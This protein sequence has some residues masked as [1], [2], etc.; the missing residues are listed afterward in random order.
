MADVR[1]E[2][3][4]EFDSVKG[5]YGVLGQ[6]MSDLLYELLRSDSIP[7]STVNFRVKDRDSLA[8]KITRKPQGH[9]QN[10]TDVTDIC[11]VRI[12]TYFED[13]VARVDDLIRREFLVDEANF[14]NK[15]EDLEDNEFGYRSVHEIISLGEP[16]CDLPENKRIKGLKAEVQ[17]RSI[18]QHAWA[19]IEHDLG[20]KSKAAVPRLVRRRFFRLAGLLELADQ[21]FMT[22]RGELE[23]YVDELPQEIVT[24]PSEVTIDK[25]SLDVFIKQD[26]GLRNADEEICELGKWDLDDSANL[27]MVTRLAAM[28]RLVDVVT[29]EQLSDGLKANHDLM[30]E[31]AGHWINGGASSSSANYESNSAPRGVAILYL[32]YVMM[33]SAGNVDIVEKFVKDHFDGNSTM[34]SR[35]ENTYRRVKGGSE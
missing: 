8:K 11:G 17:I 20:Y 5:H 18:L 34:V 31:F 26:A 13:D 1:E 24:K 15:F 27:Y 9:Y 21:E 3:L 6:K 33:L 4:R 7:I 35:L 2:I 22:I 29:I 23:K 28:L 10:L 16:R 12:V 32:C 14:V 30:L 25:L 19:E